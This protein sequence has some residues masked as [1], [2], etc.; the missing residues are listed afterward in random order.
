MSICLHM[1]KQI[2]IPELTEAITEVIKKLYSQK[3][4]KGSLL[5][6]N[7]DYFVEV[8]KSLGIERYTSKNHNVTCSKL[9]AICDFLEISLSDFFILVEKENSELKFQK[10][11]KGQLVKKAY[12]NLEKG[13]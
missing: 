6:L 9:F 10:S 13:T 8:E 3:S 11:K 12:K 4:N 2:K 7:N 1:R 5:K